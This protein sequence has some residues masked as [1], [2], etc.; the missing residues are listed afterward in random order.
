[1]D[2]PLDVIF[3]D[4]HPIFRVGLRVILEEPG[5]PALRLNGEAHDASGALALVK[6]HVP[7]VLIADLQ[8]QKDR[9]C[10]SGLDLIRQVRYHSPHTQVLVVTAF[11]ADDLLLRAIEAGANGYVFKTDSLDGREIRQAL[12]HVASGGFYYGP[13]LL[14]RLPDIIRRG[15][16]STQLP[17]ERLTPREH[18]VL[19][20]IA[21]DQSNKEI[22][23]QLCISVKT[24]KTHVSN[25]LSKLQFED[26]HQAAIYRRLQS[27]N[28]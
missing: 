13:Q 3:V 11:E 27:P 9:D 19:D 7:D 10:A 18:E 15:I 14:K 6:E 21:A 4:D 17:P 1:M 12:A 22:A 16:R 26:R 20:L 24:V 25:I 2:E 8:L 5:M 23:D 28:G